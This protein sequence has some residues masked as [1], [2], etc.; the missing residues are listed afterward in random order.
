MRAPL[1]PL[2]CLLSLL[3]ASS[4]SAVTMAWTPIG[5][6]LNAADS[7]GYGAVA[8]PYSIGTY[9]V[10]NAQYVDFLN[11]KAAADPLGLYD[12]NMASGFGGGITRTGVSGSYTYSAVA[13]R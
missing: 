7:T 10:T 5:N 13:G 6:P 11:A 9:E 4:G 1:T 3:I 12:T 8:Y 2:V